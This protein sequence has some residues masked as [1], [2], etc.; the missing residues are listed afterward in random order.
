M[1][2]TQVTAEDLEMA[3][4][5]QPIEHYG[6]IGNLRTAALVGMDGSIDWLCLPHFDSPSVFAALL[7]DGKGGRFRIAP[8]AADFRRRRCRC[9]LHSGRGRNGHVRIDPP[10]PRG[11]AAGVPRGGRGG[12]LVPRHRGLLAEV[13]QQ[14]HLS[15]SL[16]RGCASL[17]ADA[18]APV[19]PADR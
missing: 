12:G 8:A 14:V 1:T 18:E 16:A 9:R 13:E 15:G 6:I 2:A 17:R 7:D 4:R 19:L 11:S 5:Y 10:P 3:S